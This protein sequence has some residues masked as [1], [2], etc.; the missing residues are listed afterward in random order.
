MIYIIPEYFWQILTNVLPIDHFFILTKSILYSFYSILETFS[1]PIVLIWYGKI[2]VNSPG[3]VKNSKMYTSWTDNE[4][5]RECDKKI[6]GAHP[7]TTVN[8]RRW[9]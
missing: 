7:V 3:K 5:F 4:F 1:S 8:T 2:E 6:K 9:I